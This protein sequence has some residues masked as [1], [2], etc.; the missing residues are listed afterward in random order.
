MPLNVPQDKQRAALVGV[1][2]PGVSDE[3]HAS[4]L[5][6]LGRLARTL[7]LAVVARVTQKRGAL[8]ASSVL[9]KGKLKELARLTGGTGS[10]PSGAPAHRRHTD[11]ADT[12][13]DNV[14]EMVEAP[15]PGE[16]ATIVLVDHELSP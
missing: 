7:G 11:D 14:S 2:L 5:A 9:G 3:E 6:E 1:Q 8:A 13:S 4:S 16:R 10:V 12:E 15:A